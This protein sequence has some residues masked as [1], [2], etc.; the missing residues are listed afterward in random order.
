M[1]PVAS[2]ENREDAQKDVYMGKIGVPQEV[3]SVQTHKEKGT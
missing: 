1:G 2:E 3:A